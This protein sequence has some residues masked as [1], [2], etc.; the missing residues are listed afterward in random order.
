MCMVGSTV[1]AGIRQEE[2]RRDQEIQQQREKKR[3]RDKKEER[4]TDSSERRFHYCSFQIFI[5]HYLSYNFYQNNFSSLRND[6]LMIWKIDIILDSVAMQADALYVAT[7]VR[8]GFQQLI[9][10]HFMIFADFF[11]NMMQF[12]FN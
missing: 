11:Y 6:F 1:L 9:T 3:R 10:L 8:H 12:C 4:R 5:M 7:C 2:E